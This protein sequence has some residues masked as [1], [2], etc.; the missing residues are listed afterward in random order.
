[1]ARSRSRGTSRRAARNS[2][3]LIQIV[4]RVRRRPSSRRAQRHSAVAPDIGKNARRHLLG[5]RIVRAAAGEE[6]GGN[7]VGEFQDTHQM[8]VTPWIY[9]RPQSTILLSG[10]S[11]IP[12][13]PAAFKRGM[14]VRTMF[15]S[16]IVFTAIHSGSLNV[17][18]VGFFSAGSAA[19]TAA[20]FSL[21]TFSM[22]PTLVY[23]AIAPVSRRTRLEI[24]SLFQESEI[25]ARLAIN[26]V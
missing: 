5:S 6:P 25:A 10:Y 26:T 19:S 2:A 18:T 7:R 13:A 15:S 16:T 14:M 11:T 9:F 24:F 17:E 20:R 21:R 8:N 3:R 12:C 4:P 22:M 23:A 1:M